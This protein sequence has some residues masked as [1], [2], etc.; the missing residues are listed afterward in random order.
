[1]AKFVVRLYEIGAHDFTI[2]APDEETAIE[3]ARASFDAQVDA[4]AYK[5]L[6]LAP[7]HPPTVAPAPEP[8][9]GSA[10]VDRALR[11]V[12]LQLAPPP[13]KGSLH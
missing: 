9:D 2:N 7:G 13:W 4:N 1:V 12:R 5:S 10:G 3:L 11:S 6:A 8:T